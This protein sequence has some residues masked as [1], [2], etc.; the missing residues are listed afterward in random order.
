MTEEEKVKKV[1]EEEEK[2]E[3]E[4]H[5]KLS[6]IVIASLKTGVVE[7]A[8]VKQAVVA[9]AD[10]VASL[11]EVASWVEK[12]ATAIPGHFS[13]TPNCTHAITVLAHHASIGQ[14]FIQAVAGALMKALHT[15][16]MDKAS[17]TRIA[18]WSTSLIRPLHQ[19]PSASKEKKSKKTPENNNEQ[20]QQEEKEE[21]QQ[22][23]IEVY[24]PEKGI[25]DGVCK[26]ISLVFCAITRSC[27][28]MMMMMMTSSGENNNNNKQQRRDIRILNSAMHALRSLITA[29]PDACTALEKL[30]FSEKRSSYALLA[31]ALTSRPGFSDKAKAEA[32]CHAMIFDSN[33][34]NN[35]SNGSGIASWGPEG[36]P[37]YCVRSFASSVLNAPSYDFV[38]NKIIYP[39]LTVHAKRS[40]V[41]ALTLLRDALLSMG[42]L[43]G[44]QPGAFVADT[45]VPALVP[46][47]KSDKAE[48]RAA[49]HSVLTAAAQ[50]FLA[51]DS[52]EGVEKAAARLWRTMSGG[53]GPVPYA[54]QRIAVVQAI[55][56]VLE[57]GA[58]APASLTNG[59]TSALRL[60]KTETNDEVREMYFRCVGRMFAM[61]G[62][63]AEKA[64]V[65]ALLT[66]AAAAA[67][68]TL[69]KEGV[70]NGFCAALAAAA[71][72]VDAAYKQKI[73]QVAAGIVK[74]QCGKTPKV[75]F[76]GL[77]SALCALFDTSEDNAKFWNTAFGNTD[78][79][80]IYQAPFFAKL[81][82]PEQLAY[83]EAVA[84][85][86]AAATSADTK[87]QKV[88][89]A[90]FGALVFPLSS[91]HASVRQ[92]ALKRC[93]DAAAANND[94]GDFQTALTEA[95]ARHVGLFSAAA[96]TA[97]T[98]PVHPTALKACVS[99]N[100]HPEKVLPTLLVLAH[101]PLVKISNMEEEE[102]EEGGVAADDKVWAAF[103]E[104]ARIRAGRELWVTLV[105]KIF[106]RY[107]PDTLF[108]EYGDNF[109]G[110]IAGR[111]LGGG[112]VPANA[113]AVTAS[114]R[115]CRTVASDSASDSV[116]V[117]AL[118]DSL[119]KVVEA[120]APAFVASHSAHQLEL[121]STPRGTYVPDPADAA[122]SA[123][124]SSNN[125]SSSA[126]RQ[127][128]QPKRR[129]E[130]SLYRAGDEDFDR[131]VRAELEAKKRAENAGKEAEALAQKVAAQD[132]QRAALG[133][134]LLSVNGALRALAALAEA[135]PAAAEPAAAGLVYAG[136]HTLRAHP[137]AFGAI[138]REF[139]EAVCCALSDGS[140][141][142]RELGFAAAAA[143]CDV[144]AESPL[145]APAVA[146]GAGPA[147]AEIAAA[148]RLAASARG[149]SATSATHTHLPL[150]PHGAYVMLVPAIKAGMFMAQS[151]ETNAL[152]QACVALL[153]SHV[154]PAAQYSRAEIAA[155]MVRGMTTF[156]RFQMKLR[157][158]L[159]DLARGI[160][161]ADVQPLIDGVYS[162]DAV[163][164][165][166][167]FEA[168][169]NSAIF[170]DPDAPKQPFH[171]GLVY[172]LWVKRCEVA[173]AGNSA[174]AS[175]SETAERLW[176]AYGHALPSPDFVEPLKALLLGE[177]LRASALAASGLAAA[178]AEHPKT[179]D[180][181]AKKLLD[182]YKAQLPEN[183]R[184]QGAVLT[185]DAFEQEDPAA[186]RRRLEAVHGLGALAQ[187]YASIE[188][189]TRVLRFLLNQAM[190]DVEDVRLAALAAGSDIVAAQGA[191]HPDELFTYLNEHLRKC[192]GLGP[193]YRD[194]AKS[195]TT[196]L[197]A[198]VVR[199]CPEGE[200][201]EARITE[202]VAHLRP[203]LFAK[204]ASE[205]L[206]DA[207][208]RCF[209]AVAPLASPEAREALVKGFLASTVGGANAGERRGSAYALAGLVKG[210]GLG[211]IAKYGVLAG[212]KEAFAAKKPGPPQGA[213]FAFELISARLQRAFE[214]YVAQV[215][216]LILA[217]YGDDRVEVRK[218]ADGAARV[219]I[220]NISAHC[221]K[222]II[223]AINKS[224]E[225]PQ[226]RTKRSSVE[227]LGNMAAYA[228]QQTSA[229]LPRIVPNLLGV[230]I[231]THLEV[232]NAALGALSAIA[233]VI[234]N[235]EIIT[236]LPAILDALRNPTECTRAA[237][238][239]LETTDFVHKI[240]AP[241]LSLVVPVLRRGLSSDDAT[242]K[243]MG[244]RI[245]GNMCSLADR[246]DL[247]DYLPSLMTLLRTNIID[248]IPDVRS[249]TAHALGTL[250]AGNAYEGFEELFKWLVDTMHSP[251][252]TVERS[253]AAQA[254]S[255]VF[256]G[257]GAERLRGI[258]P[259][260]IRQV[261]SDVSCVR[262][263]SLALFRYLPFTIPDVFRDYIPEAYAGVFE[264]VVHEE[265]SVWKAARKAGETITEVYWDSDTP[266]V[267]PILREAMLDDNWHVQEVAIVLMQK[268]FTR[269]LGTDP[270]LAS[271]DPSRL[272]I[273]RLGERICYPLF[274]TIFMLRFEDTTDVSQKAVILWKNIITNPPKMLI[275]ILSVFLDT[276]VAILSSP[277]QHR[278]DLASKALGDLVDR[279]SVRILPS[280]VP[281]L[282][283]HLDDS[284][285]ITRRGVCLYLEEIIRSSG[286]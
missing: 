13:E 26:L 51:K 10:I 149:T 228:P 105:A 271:R 119:T 190:A 137:A 22:Q 216:P 222:T 220:S 286:K 178:V 129:G 167:C 139:L 143:M 207:I 279:L 273:D 138:A 245:V 283:E 14:K 277:S 191:A 111:I 135:N 37:G 53:D 212:L 157:G 136:L 115:A 170:A 234:R 134:E 144:Y 250:V 9:S 116:L 199:F 55:T 260:L 265:E 66:A 168:L 159:I 221:A 83:T 42:A 127:T 229:Y 47:L 214:P 106:G 145:E 23:L 153:V 98:T 154:D 284:S 15:A 146:V 60:E 258:L 198:L 169:A 215:I 263:G 130:G 61:Y 101:H 34:N 35:N 25:V 104:A 80:V 165:D 93:N 2:E 171:A 78:T 253:G 18:I 194:F 56:T 62:L 108:E 203:L 174:A 120:G 58:A 166:A 217:S 1:K 242:A 232:R 160:G 59:V 94:D 36:V 231:D 270:L 19:Q 226:W 188:Q 241:S 183:G 251:R 123:A 187:E 268:V 236:V 155:A 131:Q 67:S 281:V 266:T 267:A 28:G 213:L 237:L 128:R 204:G 76:G 32:L 27:R 132:A 240:D 121:M 43:P 4:E 11:K 99:V 244:A 238:S 48:V 117:Q 196:I 6:D 269:L 282:Q 278:Q 41:V 70:C 185:L 33:S 285:E 172:C 112:A 218:A 206:L 64:A 233:S 109:C 90:L 175:A 252:D 5:K 68:R 254:L 264:S 82:E 181:V 88:R 162:D 272:C 75:A 140:G 110:V 189:V 255:E 44:A 31:A 219:I 81:A 12:R 280:I 274:A 126:K 24:N 186:V 122:A 96:V 205:L 225:D 202:T 57:C 114:V 200:Q 91:A 63:V 201:R 38:K 133:R 118:F 20:Q 195:A 150:L 142:S 173:A 7:H 100:A 30:T 16:G 147:F 239:A 52:A 89:Q 49:A 74:T 107:T 148:V 3:K 276:L 230:L 211:A 197:I 208:A 85:A 259:G 152:H 249:T 113:A 257:L 102:K 184:Q 40:P 125:S 192:E 97:K 246:R 193:L 86:A 156:A 262:E 256:V 45:L 176:N 71:K 141:V 163:V 124:A 243:K 223:P 182:A 72:H 235:P 87:A 210:L 84:T 73:A 227:L 54:A 103:D 29:S 161:V 50:R 224:V 17:L 79:G 151:A 209:T 179:L 8:A 177:S 69:D 261:H 21:E 248:P 158:G 164:S 180:S 275:E 46:H 92:A 39:V 65:D 77:C 95:V 247:A